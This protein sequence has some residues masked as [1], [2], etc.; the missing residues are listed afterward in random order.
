VADGDVSLK[1]KL[2]GEDAGASRAFNKVGGA[3]EHLHTR[4]TAV[5]VAIGSLAAGG[6]VALGALAV[7][8]VRTG[9]TTA[10]A[11]QQAEI[12]FKH[13]LGSAQKAQEFIGQLSVFAAKT[14]FEMPGLVDAA[15]TLLGVGVAAKDVIPT[16]TAYGDAASALGIQQDA[17]QRIMIA[18]TQSMSAGKIKLGDMNQLANNGLPIWKLLADALHKPVPEIQDLISHG[19]LLSADVLPKLQAQMEKPDVY[20]GAMAEQSKT[21]AGL[22]STMVDTFSQGM[23]K[24]LMPLVP[25][26]QKVLPG[27][28]D[29]LGK[30]FQGAADWISAAIPKVQGFATEA[31]PKL[32]PLLHAL[33]AIITSVAGWVRDEL[34]PVIQKT[35]AQVFPAVQ[36]AV[37]TVSAAFRDHQGMVNLVVAAFKIMA[38][39]TTTIL[40]PVIGQLVS[41]VMATL[42]PAFRVIGTLVEAVVIPAFKLMMNAFMNTAGAIVDGA[43]WAFGWIPGIG[44]K[45]KAAQTAFHKFRDDVNAALAGITDRNV[46][47]RV[48]VDTTTGQTYQAESKHR[49]MGGPVTAGVPYIVG[50][51]GLELFVPTQSGTIIP[52]HKVGS[53]SS[54]GG[55]G[56]THIHL[57]LGSG[58]VGSAREIGVAFSEALQRA[59]AQGIPINV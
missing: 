25:L 46:H 37:A 38:S 47:V 27:A 31:G 33:G 44:P 11:L 52:N 16:L 34:I 40:I 39:F 58:F 3:S 35:A 49:A 20:G 24:V 55:G 48:Q 12:G 4:M 5:G 53:S 10:S 1:F 56:D 29:F 57:N 42:G 30:A 23:A 13:M 2:L 18:V 14:P 8:A 45:L 26:L 51:K 17:F 43:A 50:E 41:A 36:N 15:R 9:I 6:A 21:L 28:M 54:G 7:G 32:T 22:W 19:K 59:R